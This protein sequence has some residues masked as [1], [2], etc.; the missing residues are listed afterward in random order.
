MAENIVASLKPGSG[1]CAILF[2]H[3]VLF[4]N[5]EKEMRRNLIRGIPAGRYGTPEEMAAMVSFLASD[6]AAYVTGHT[7]PVDGG[8]LAAGVLEI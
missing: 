6:D 3:G 2:P 5:E 7:F 1:R 4:R 8:L